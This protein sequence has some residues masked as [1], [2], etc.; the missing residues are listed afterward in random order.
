MRRIQKHLKLG[1]RRGVFWLSFGD[2]ARYR[3][4]TVT[5]L[6]TEVRRAGGDEAL[7]LG[8]RDPL[9]I[10]TSMVEAAPLLVAL[11]PKAV[12]VPRLEKAFEDWMT[13]QPVFYVGNRINGEKWGWFL[14]EAVPRGTWQLVPAGFSEQDHSVFDAS[15]SFL[16]S[17]TSGTVSSTILFKDSVALELGNGDNENVFPSWSEVYYGVSDV[18][19]LIHA[20][21][22]RGDEKT[23]LPSQHWDEKPCPVCKQNPDPD[24]EYGLAVNVPG[25]QTLM[26][27]C[28]ERIV[29]PCAGHAKSGAA[30]LFQGRTYVWHKGRW[31]LPSHLGRRKPVPQERQDKEPMWIN[32]AEAAKPDPS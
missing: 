28:L 4:R 22:E 21:M 9:T 24:Y 14:Q 25:H 30:V 23:G 20:H 6:V 29:K 13:A 16:G 31:E 18:A 19:D 12:L 17:M 10:R 27:E 15:Y 1:R 3:G 7:F 11:R 8:A 2:S 5:E 26:G 32:A